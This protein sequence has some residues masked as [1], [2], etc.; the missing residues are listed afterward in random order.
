MPANDEEY[1]WLLKECLELIAI[2]AKSV[3]TAEKNREKKK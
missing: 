1:T 2:L 3:N